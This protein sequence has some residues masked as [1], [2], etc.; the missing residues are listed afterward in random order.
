LDSTSR[1]EFTT[2]T[3]DIEVDVAII[4]GGMVGITSAYLLG[5]EGLST[6][7]IEAD[8]ILRGTTGHTTAKITSQHSLIY[9]QLKK[10][11][12]EE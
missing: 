2:L 1:P 11:V 12:G 4:G 6:A 9:A 5:Q 10:K 8:R 3:E 7:I